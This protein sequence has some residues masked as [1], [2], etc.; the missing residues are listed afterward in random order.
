MIFNS[1]QFIWLLPLIFIVYWS[2]VLSKGSNNRTTNCILLIIS[3]GLYAQWNLQYTFILFGVTLITYSFARIIELKRTCIG[4]K[5]YLIW[6]GVLLTLLPLLIFKYCNFITHAGASALAWIGIDTTSANLNWVVPLGLSFYTFQ[7]LGYLWDVYYN[8][9]KAE[10]NLIDY[11]LFVAFF[12]QIVC[13]P[14]S[15]AEE[16]LPQIKKQ[17]VFN[18]SQAVSGLRYLLYGM[19]MKVVLADRLGIYVDTVFTDPLYFT[20]SS[21]L[22]AAIFYSIQIYGDFAGYSFLALGVAKLLGYDIIKNFNRPYFATSI[23]MFW[24]RWNISLT[25]WLKD[26]IYIPMGGSRKGTLITYR[27]IM[28]TFLVSGIWHG[29]NWTFIFWGVIHGF[30]QC[31][32]KLFGLNNTEKNRWMIFMKIILTF[33]IVTFAWIFFRLPSINEGWSVIKHVFSFGSVYIDPNT[34]IHLAIALPLVFSI[35][36]IQEYYPRLYLTIK[37]NN[38][39]R[40]T[41]YVFL[42]M[43]IIIFGVLDSSQF[44]YLIF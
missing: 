42:F 29:A 26:Y 14:I 8:K 24:K 22:L 39:I 6:C 25:Q 19:F 5:H 34:F 33:L 27:N 44:I 4:K 10:T 9:I 7:A 15:K 36:F 13:G 3:Y 17:K 16:L 37:A 28:I 11:M 1:F 2:I 20:G 41:S 21:N 30:T 32:E 23:S 38:F 43:S 31:V 18:Y 40:W 35:E 12:P